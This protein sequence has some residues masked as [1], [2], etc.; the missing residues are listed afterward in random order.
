M[1]AVPHQAN[2]AATQPFGARRETRRIE[3]RSRAQLGAEAGQSRSCLV[4]RDRKT[5]I[6][7]WAVMWPATT[8][9]TAS[10]SGA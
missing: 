6:M 8:A 2:E 3:R 9:S 7:S 5:S 1:P 10:V 4:S